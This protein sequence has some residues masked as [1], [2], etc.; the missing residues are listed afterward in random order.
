MWESSH[1]KE[2][3]V[4]QKVVRFLIEL[5]RYKNGLYDWGIDENESRE[6]AKN[7]EYIYIFVSCHTL[8]FYLLG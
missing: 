2:N 8:G 4:G 3:E 7:V 1:K 6:N 5:V